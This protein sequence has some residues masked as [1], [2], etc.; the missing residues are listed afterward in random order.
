MEYDIIL[1]FDGSTRSRLM[2]ELAKR[3]NKKIFGLVVS[4]GDESDVRAAVEIL[5]ENGIKYRMVE[6]VGVG[7]VD[8]Y[9]ENVINVSI[10]LSIAWNMGIDEIW[11]DG[12]YSSEYVQ[13]IGDLTYV[14]IKTPLIGFADEDVEMLLNSFSENTIEVPKSDRVHFRKNEWKWT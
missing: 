9:S 13:G 6:I 11:I 1:V 4:Y 2:L 5:N 7:D 3:M 14:K 10:A 8:K 12:K